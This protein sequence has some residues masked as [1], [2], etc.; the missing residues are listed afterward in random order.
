MFN[1]AQFCILAVNASLSI[2]ILD[3][4]SVHLP[5]K[6]DPATEIRMALL[7]ILIEII[8]NSKIARDRVITIAKNL[9]FFVIFNGITARNKTDIFFG[10]FFREAH[11]F[12]I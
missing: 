10:I 12:R 7:N 5:A 4:D 8:E 6:A 1:S 9:I 11:C 3:S 2:H